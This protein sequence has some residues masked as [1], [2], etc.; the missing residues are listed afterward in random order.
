VNSRDDLVALVGAEQERILEGFVGLA[1]HVGSP[2]RLQFRGDRALPRPSRPSGRRTPRSRNGALPE[3]H[4]T[5]DLQHG[6]G[7]D[8]PELIRARAVRPLVDGARPGGT[9]DR[10]RAATCWPWRFPRGPGGPSDGDTSRYA[11]PLP[12]LRPK[13]RQPGTRRTPSSARWRLSPSG[14]ATQLGPC[15][16]WSADWTCRPVSLVVFPDG[17]WC[18]QTAEPAPQ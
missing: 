16:A 6:A 1:V 18:S 12:T 14:S 17:L 11:I 7:W 5:A 10:L 3:P 2:D 9:A 15:S 8:R 4:P 13:P